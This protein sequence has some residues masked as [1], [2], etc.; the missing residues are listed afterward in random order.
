MRSITNATCCPST[1]TLPPNN[2]GSPVLKELV[3]GMKSIFKKFGSKITCMARLHA[4]KSQKNR[5]VGQRANEYSK[6]IDEK[7]LANWFSSTT[8][9]DRQL[10]DFISRNNFESKSPTYSEV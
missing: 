3:V 6:I 7:V 2:F 1:K 4:Y 10:A 5:S 9:P 8:K